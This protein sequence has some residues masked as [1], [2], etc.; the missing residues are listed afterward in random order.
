MKFFSFKFY[1]F[2]SGRPRGVDLGLAVDELEQPDGRVDCFVVVG[3]EGRGLGYHGRAQ[4]PGLAHPVK[5]KITLQ[6]RQV[7]Y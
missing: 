3:R 6:L 4:N 2:Q 7:S 5:S 1:Q